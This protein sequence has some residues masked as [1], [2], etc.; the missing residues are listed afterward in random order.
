MKK[1]IPVGSA[2]AALLFVGVAIHAAT[3]AQIDVSATISA[4][5]SLNAT[6]KTNTTTPVDAPSIAFGN[7]ASTEGSWAAS[8]IPPYFVQI[9]VDKND[10]NWRLRLSTK[11]MK[12][13][14]PADIAYTTT[15]WGYSFGG[16]VST[17]TAGGK[18]PFAWRCSTSTA[19]GA[20]PAAGNP[21]VAGSGWTFVKDQEDLDD[22]SAAA[23]GNQSFEW[24]DTNTGYC[25]IAFGGPSYTNVVAINGNVTQA[26]IEPRTASFK[27]FLNANFNGA[28]AAGY[29]PA[30]ANATFKTAVTQNKLV[31]DLL[32]S[33]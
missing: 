32:N 13:L 6:L 1:I 14:L 10:S 4:V 28:R 23:V 12:E 17:T 2:V 8:G 22:P 30:P 9:A 3:N 20:T 5:S 15:T 21:A 16:L 29:G 25:N 11:N 19:N 7:H 18:I 33:I 31:L 26:P 24:V 27:L